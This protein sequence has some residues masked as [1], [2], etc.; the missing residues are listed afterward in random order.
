MCTCSSNV[1]KNVG[2]KYVKM[3]PN[4]LRP[5]LSI[6]LHVAGHTVRVAV[7]PRHVGLARQFLVAEEA[8]EVSQ[9]PVTIVGPC[10][11]VTED[12]LHKQH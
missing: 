2:Y 5:Y 3:K 6:S 8:S 1:G 7:G 10:P 11:R 9:V 12:Q 4:T